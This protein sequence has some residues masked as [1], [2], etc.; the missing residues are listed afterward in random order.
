VLFHCLGTVANV[1]GPARSTIKNLRQTQRL[2]A[3]NLP[4]SG[5]SRAGMLS[6]RDERAVQRAAGK[7]RSLT[8][9]D[10]RIN[11]GAGW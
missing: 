4:R 3:G 10:N 2:S 8:N 11:R 9:E 5:R 1:I 6:R 7:T